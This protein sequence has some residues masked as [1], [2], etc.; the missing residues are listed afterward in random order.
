MKHNDELDRWWEKDPLAQGNGLGLVL[1]EQAQQW[2]VVNVL[3]DS[4]AE[5]VGVSVGDVL[6]QVDDYELPDGDSLELLGLIR[7]GIAK[8]R[9]HLTLHRK[10]KGHLKLDIG[11][12]PLP[13]I[14]EAHARLAGGFGLTGL[15]RTC[16]RCT[17]TAIG[18]T[19]CG[20]ETLSAAGTR[21]S[22]RC[23]VA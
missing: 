17:P 15:C 21:C 18:W 16:K 20:R 8:R 14:L 22:G 9:Y 4:P 19:D 10:E 12:R 7:S 3:R 11:P 1:H 5:Q 23:L 6:M 13:G 2:I